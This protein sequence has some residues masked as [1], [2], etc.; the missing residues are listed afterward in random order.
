MSRNLIYLCM[1]THL[2]RL[3]NQ[4][5]KFICQ[6]CIQRQNLFQTDGSGD[7][8]ESSHLGVSGDWYSMVF[9]S[10]ELH[11]YHKSD[12]EWN[13]T[14]KIYKYFLDTSIERNTVGQKVVRVPNLYFGSIQYSWGTWL[15]STSTSPKWFHH[16]VE[17]RMANISWLT[18]NACRQLW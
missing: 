13:I 16:V 17:V 1:C 8:D 14:F 7:F 6:P 15:A 4:P 2:V 5:D 3:P 11:W 18:L 12:P 10:P 9:Y